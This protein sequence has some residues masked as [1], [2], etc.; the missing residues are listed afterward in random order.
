MKFVKVILDLFISSFGHENVWH[1]AQVEQGVDVTAV[2]GRDR[3]F[4]LDVGSMLYVFAISG[5]F[6][7]L[8]FEP[9][10]KYYFV[11]KFQ[12]IYS[13]SLFFKKK[14]TLSWIHNIDPTCFSSFK[15][16]E[17][18]FGGVIDTIESFESFE[19][20]DL[21][22]AARCFIFMPKLLILVYYGGPWM[23][24]VGIFYGHLEYFK[25]ICYSVWPFGKFVALWYIIPPFG[26]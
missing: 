20:K 5:I 19:D 8:D 24:N 21:S 22:R 23:E 15:F 14:W 4:P 9:F 12:N 6:S 16:E 13:K 17:S 3:A 25:I 26:M 7:Y 10:L 18:C 11:K 2:H 1:V